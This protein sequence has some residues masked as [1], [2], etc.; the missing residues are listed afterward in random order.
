MYVWMVAG[1]YECERAYVCVHML[2]LRG[3]LLLREV[4]RGQ[5]KGPD[6]EVESAGGWLVGRHGGLGPREPAL[7]TSLV[8]IQ[9]VAICPAV[10]VPAW[11]QVVRS[12]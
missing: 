11:T 6:G 4:S 12:T 9:T 7:S 3:C 2:C 10:C 5:E 1:T 8:L